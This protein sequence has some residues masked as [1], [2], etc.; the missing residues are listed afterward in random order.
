M[1]HVVQL[2]S[3]VW[4]AGWSGD[5]GRTLDPSN[6]KEFLSKRAA[7]SALAAARKHRPFKNARIIPLP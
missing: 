5:P 7:T 3:G 2:E 1:K 4:L 6:A